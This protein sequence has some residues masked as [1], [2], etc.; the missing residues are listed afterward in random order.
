M[1]I[2]EKLSSIRKDAYLEYLKVSYKMHD[3]KTMFTDEKE[4]IV[5]Q[6]Y[7][8]YKEIEERID[9]VEFLTEME[10]LERDRPIEVQI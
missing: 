5:R 9:E 1:S 7:K 3:D 2:Q 10:E 6:A 4:A 8:K